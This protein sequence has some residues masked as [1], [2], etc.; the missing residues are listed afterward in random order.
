[1]TRETEESGGPHGKTSRSDDAVLLK[2]QGLVR[3]FDSLRALDGADL[4]VHSDT[5]TGLI[6]PNGAG[7]TT[8][9]N[10]VTGFH[11]AQGGRVTLNG[12]DITNLPPHR[13]FRHG[14]CRTFQIP[15]EHQSL[16]VLENLMLVPIGQQGEGLFNAWLRPGAVRRQ[17]LANRK[18]A[19]EVLEFVDLSHVRDEY[20][21]N[22]SGGQKKLLELARTL[23]TDPTLVLLDEPGA[24]VNP[25]LMHRLTDNIRYLNRERGITFLVIEHDMDMIMSLCDPVVV[26][27]EGRQLMTGSPEE[28]RRDPR[29]LEAYLG[30]QYATVEG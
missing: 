20:A 6:G 28:V 30:G 26:M 13:I 19:L 24:G 27:S 3:D 17:E 22:L 10:V 12:Q 15:R 14:L 9:F 25:T 2:V 11:L 5:I 23:M 21:R 18:K 29:V 16:S 8:L 4:E 7:K 1:M